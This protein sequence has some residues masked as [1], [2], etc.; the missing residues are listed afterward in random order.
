MMKDK[1]HAVKGSAAY[2]GASRISNDWY[3]IQVWFENREYVKMMQHYLELLEHAAQFRVYW[4]MVYF[5]HLKQPYLRKPQ[6][7]GVP[8]PAGYALTKV[9]EFDFKVSHPV[10]YLELAEE[11]ERRGKRYVKLE[12]D[13]AGIIYTKDEQNDIEAMNSN[14]ILF[15]TANNNDQNNPKSIYYNSNLLQF[16]EYKVN[17]IVS[18]QSDYSKVEYSWSEDSQSYKSWLSGM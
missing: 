15:Q 13:K 8:L 5:K 4:R 17:L 7:E 16:N 11:A 12:G 6:D 10:D 14:D 3:W 18:N 2:A 1:A 9:G